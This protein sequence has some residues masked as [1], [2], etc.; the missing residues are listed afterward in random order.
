MRVII[1]QFYPYLSFK[2]ISRRE[3]KFFRLNTKQGALNIMARKFRK[4]ACFATLISNCK[5]K[6]RKN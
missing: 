2:T 1:F 6:K 4:V 5:K 3:S